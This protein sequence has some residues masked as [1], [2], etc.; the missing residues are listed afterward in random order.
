MRDVYTIK[1]NKILTIHFLN[2]NAVFARVIVHSKWCDFVNKGG[3]F[4]ALLSDLL[5]TFFDGET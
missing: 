4:A 5:K 3:A 2:I 1:C